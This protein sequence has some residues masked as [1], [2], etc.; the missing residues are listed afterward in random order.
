MRG[1]Q[2]DREGAAPVGSPGARDDGVARRSERA[3]KQFVYGALV[4]TAVLGAAGFAMVKEST[5]AKTTGPIKLSDLTLDRAFRYSVAFPASSPTVISAPPTI[6]FVLTYVFAPSLGSFPTLPISI[7]GGE[8]S[9]IPCGFSS[10]SGQIVDGN[11]HHPI[12]IRPGDTLTV[13]TSSLTVTF[14]GYFVYPGEV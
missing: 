1:G 11:L 8:I 13:Y 10:M 3:M 5:A 7:N 12:V 4:A 6:G 2:F 14:G 9:T